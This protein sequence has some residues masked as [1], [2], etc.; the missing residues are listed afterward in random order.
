MCI[1][2]KVLSLLKMYC[3]SQYFWIINCA[4]FIKLKSHKKNI[5]GKQNRFTNMS[6]I[7]IA[8]TTR[9]GL[10]ILHLLQMP[11]KAATVR[12]TIVALKPG[13]FPIEVT[14]IVSSKGSLKTDMIIKS[15]YVEVGIC[16][17]CVYWF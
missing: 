5:P 4:L 11:H 8:L 9:S 6:V 15:L 10:I 17:F 13:E 2:I 3:K 1:I 16:F 7:F 12:F 14:A